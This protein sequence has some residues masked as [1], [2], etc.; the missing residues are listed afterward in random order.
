MIY[1]NGNISCRTNNGVHS[2]WIQQTT[3]T[4]LYILVFR[5]RFQLWWNW[6]FIIPA[7]TWAHVISEYHSNNF[8]IFLILNTVDKINMNI[9][10]YLLYFLSMGNHLDQLHAVFGDLNPALTPVK[11]RYFFLS[12]PGCWYQGFSP[13][14]GNL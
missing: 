9:R 4:A 3:L 11:T 5:C 13:S 10:I 14:P 7:L 1:L 12:R 6:G 2:I 8:S